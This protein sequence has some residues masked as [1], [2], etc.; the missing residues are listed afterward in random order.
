MGPGGIATIIA[1][2]SL[3][4]IAI[5]VAYAVV[6]VGRLVDKAAPL[7]EEVTLTVELINGPLQSINKVTKTVEGLTTKISDSTEGFLEKTKVAMSAAS[8]LLA[9]SKMKK[10]SETK[11]KKKKSAKSE[12]ESE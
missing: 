2:A 12:K 7:L 10:S 11:T 8:A 6:R 4:V 1:A 3:F 5:A 9:V